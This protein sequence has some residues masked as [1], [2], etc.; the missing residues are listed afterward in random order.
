LGHIRWNN[1]TSGSSNV[2]LGADALLGNV[3]GSGNTAIGASNASF[4]TG[5]DNTALGGRLWYFGFV[6]N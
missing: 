4:S 6:P 3:T 1:N 2:A 5:D